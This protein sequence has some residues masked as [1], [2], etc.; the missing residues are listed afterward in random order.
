MQTCRPHPQRQVLDDGRVAISYE[1]R[2]GTIRALQA[3]G[4]ELV[5]SVR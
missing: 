5:L 3:L 1:S 4:K 2:G